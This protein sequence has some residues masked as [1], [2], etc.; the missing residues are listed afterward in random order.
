VVEVPSTLMEYFAFE[1][2]VLKSLSGHYSTGE[3]LPDDVLASI[4]RQRKLF[5]AL[6]TLQQVTYGL[7]D[8]ELH[9]A[10]PRDEEPPG[11][12]Y[13]VAM[14]ASAARSPVSPPP[15]CFWY[16]D[17]SHLAS[18]GANYYSYMWS[19]SLSA[20]VWRAHFA[21]EPRRPLAGLPFLQ[22]FLSRGGSRRGHDMLL[23]VLHGE[24]Y[25]EGPAGARRM[26]EDMDDACSAL[27]DDLLA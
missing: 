20:L 4:D 16:A 13:R 27:L 26:Q 21:S 2:S 10:T 14:A 1:R 6:D 25:R 24:D 22:G 11:W 3:P 18:Y 9:L 19:R 17:L 15:G 23:A 12:S 7:I 5:P 8:L